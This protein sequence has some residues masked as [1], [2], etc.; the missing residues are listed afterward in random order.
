MAYQ[1][2]LSAVFF[3]LGSFAAA[4]PA[5]GLVATGTDTHSNALPATDST[6]LSTNGIADACQD[7]TSALAPYEGVARRKPASGSAAFCYLASVLR[8]KP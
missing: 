3:I 8:P 7:S 4:R 1:W 2:R 6:P 5:F